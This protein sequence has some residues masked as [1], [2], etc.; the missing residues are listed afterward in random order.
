[1]EHFIKSIGLSGLIDIVVM[2]VLVYSLIVWFRRSKAVFVLIGLFIVG[3]VYN[4]A[5]EF[6][7]QLLATVFQGFFTV[8]LIAIIVIFQEEIKHMFERVALWS[9][10]RGRTRQQVLNL[11]RQEVQIL[12]RAIKD[13]A[14]AKIGALIV[15]RG[16]DPIVRH[17]NGGWDLNG[18]LSE[19]VLKSLF[20]P[21]SMGHDGAMIIEGN[22]I[23]HFGCHLPLSK[24]LDKIPARGTRHAAALG[25]AELTDALCIVVSEERG[26]V[27][28][29]HKGEIEVIDDHERL[30]LVLERFYDESSPARSEKKMWDFL[31]KNLKE[32]VV[33]ILLT[34]GL[35]FFY[36]HEGR[37]TY[38]AY[39]VPVEYTNLPNDLEVSEI[40]PPEIEVTLSGP[41]R[42]FF[43]MS[44]KRI[45]LVLNMV[46]Q[47]EGFI[48]KP[49]QKSN[50]ATPPQLSVEGT[51]PTKV[52]LV[53]RTKVSKN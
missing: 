15:L 7:M 3:V 36:V 33:A 37:L 17:I 44:K 41:R 12:V 53:L 50:L 5:R 21:H 51:A 49:I 11:S 16:Q 18:E 14:D 40:I 34:I 23:L 29:A 31:I 30:N 10:N 35:W 20:D 27:S 38:Q 19:P 2:S 43:F 1:M 48:I 4:A 42:H 47:E 6:N 46:N 52:K 45:R 9:L 8:I 22:R 32:K 28:I 26:T 39:R 13:L 25:L 24:D